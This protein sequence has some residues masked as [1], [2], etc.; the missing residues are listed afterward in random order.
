[1]TTSFLS[2]DHH[3]H[4]EKVPQAILKL[5]DLNNIW[6]TFC[7]SSFFARDILRAKSLFDTEFVV[8]VVMLV[9]S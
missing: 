1:M 9:G 8:D 6:D 2:S 7:W 3:G 4:V 5:Y